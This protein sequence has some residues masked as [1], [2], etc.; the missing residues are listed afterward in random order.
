MGL[1]EIALVLTAAFAYFYL[2]VFMTSSSSVGT[3]EPPKIKISVLF[4]AAICGNL[5]R[6]KGF[7]LFF[8]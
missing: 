3:R 8:K 4:K 2:L 5:S 1:A 7:K 6:G